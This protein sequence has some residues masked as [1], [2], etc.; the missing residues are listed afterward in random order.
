MWCMKPGCCSLHT[1]CG[2]GA[3]MHSACNMQG[4]SRACAPCSVCTRQSLHTGSRGGLWAP[5]PSSGPWGW[6]SLTTRSTLQN[7][8]RLLPVGVNWFSSFTVSGILHQRTPTK[9]LTL[10][11]KCY[12]EPSVTDHDLVASGKLE[13]SSSSPSRRWGSRIF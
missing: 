5:C 9:A 1:V 8:V 4:Q 2:A 7:A 11:F 3:G 12:Q 6:M 10:M 13:D